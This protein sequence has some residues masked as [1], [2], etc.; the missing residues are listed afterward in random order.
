MEVMNMEKVGAKIREIRERKGLSL[1]EVAKRLGIGHAYL[2]RV[3]NDKVSPNVETLAK[4]AEA[5][6]CEISDFFENKIEADEELKNEG[7]RWV[8]FGKELEKEGITL[9]QVKEWVRAIKATRKL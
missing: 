4:I 6:G 8:I 3:E 5:L 2:S 9:E 7:V 1:R